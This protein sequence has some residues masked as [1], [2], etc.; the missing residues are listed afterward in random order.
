MDHVPLNWGILQISPPFRSKG[1]CKG[2]GASGSSRAALLARSWVRV[3]AKIIR[4]WVGIKKLENPDGLQIRPFFLLAELPCLFIF[5]PWNRPVSGSMSGNNFWYSLIWTWLLEQIYILS[6]RSVA[7]IPTDGIQCFISAKEPSKS[8]GNSLPAR[9]EVTASRGSLHV[10]KSVVQK[11]TTGLNLQKNGFDPPTWN[12]TKK[13]YG[14]SCTIAS[15]RVAEAANLPKSS[16]PPNNCRPAAHLRLAHA[17]G[18][19]D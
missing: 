10:S 2:L 15:N 13:K 19:C 9:G 16:Q 5:A 7:S 14:W 4:L 12:L 6:Y 18:R 8:M 11:Q 1:C 17:N 3:M